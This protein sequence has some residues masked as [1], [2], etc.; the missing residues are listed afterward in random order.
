MKVNN[1]FCG[2][3]VCPCMVLDYMSLLIDVNERAYFVFPIKYV[4]A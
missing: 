2:M 1:P 3:C 4:S